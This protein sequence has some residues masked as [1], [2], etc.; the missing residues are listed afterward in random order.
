[1]SD[2]V[3]AINP[4]KDTLEDLTRRMQQHARAVLEQRDIT[5]DF[6]R[7]GRYFYFAARR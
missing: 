7:T 1:M 5:L 2:I 6:Q 3:W 4:T